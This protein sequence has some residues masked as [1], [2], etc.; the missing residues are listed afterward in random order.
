[1]PITSKFEDGQVFFVFSSF[2]FKFFC[3]LSCGAQDSLMSDTR[4]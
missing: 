1:M 4:L 3:L 2:F